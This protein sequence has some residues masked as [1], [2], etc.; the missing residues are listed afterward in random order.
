MKTTVVGNSQLINAKLQTYEQPNCLL[1]LKVM[2][3]NVK[4]K[5]LLQNLLPS[6]KYTL[7][8]QLKNKFWD[9]REAPANELDDDDDV[10]N[11]ASVDLPDM[12]W[13]PSTADVIRSKIT[14]YEISNTPC[15][16]FR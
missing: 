12:N 11:S 10:V 13:I 9:N 1:K 5:N 3:N 6:N 14:G 15:E 7:S 8:L 2:E 16:H 4:S